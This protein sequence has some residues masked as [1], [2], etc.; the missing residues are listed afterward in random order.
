MINPALQEEMSLNIPDEGVVVCGMGERN[1]ARRFLR[2]GDVIV[3]MN[4]REIEKPSDVQYV[5]D[6]I[7]S[8]GLELILIRNGR[9]QILNLR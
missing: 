9:Q 7:D 8:R 3:R 6:R 2:E 5:A 1:Y 4:G